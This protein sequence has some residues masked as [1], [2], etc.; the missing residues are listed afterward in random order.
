MT[1]FRHKKN[2]IP[3]E[4]GIQKTGKSLDFC[5]HRNDALSKLKIR[6]NK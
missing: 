3:A 4:A 1:N 5:C 2:V 6:D